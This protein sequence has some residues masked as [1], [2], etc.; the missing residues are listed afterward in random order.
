M[1]LDIR[2]DKYQFD[3]VRHKHYISGKEVTGTTTVWE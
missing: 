3:E 2:C 1:K